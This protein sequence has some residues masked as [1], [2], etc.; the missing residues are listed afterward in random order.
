MDDQGKLIGLPNQMNGT[1]LFLNNRRFADGGLDPA[2]DAPKTWDDV[3][4]LNEK[5]TIRDAS[6]TV[7]KKGFEFRYA[8]GPYWLVEIFHALAYQ[9][10]GEFLDDQGQ[11]VFQEEPGVRAR[12]R[13]RS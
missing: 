12:R 5:L 9:V 2:A 13:G 10:G 1:S 6:G 11:P 3:A 4:T 8:A 7:T